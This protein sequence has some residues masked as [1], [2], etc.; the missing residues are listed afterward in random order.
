[1]ENDPRRKYPPATV[2][3]N[4]LIALVQVGIDAEIK[5]LKWVIEEQDDGKTDRH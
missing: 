1:M 4:A 5:A 2:P 3:V